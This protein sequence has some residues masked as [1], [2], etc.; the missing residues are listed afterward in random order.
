M[1]C[2]YEPKVSYV[3]NTDANGNSYVESKSTTYSCPWGSD[4]EACKERKTKK[5]MIGTTLSIIAVAIIVGAV[6]CFGLM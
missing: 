3:M 2:K 4:C 1:K 6:I 5:L